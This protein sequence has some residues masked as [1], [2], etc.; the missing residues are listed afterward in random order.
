MS[1]QTT[2]SYDA[3]VIGAGVIGACLALGLAK[4][5][6][7]KV[8]L[9]EKN[10]T[11][12]SSTFTPEPNIR[13]TALG[14]SSQSLLSDLGV[15]QS[16]NEQQV[17]AY[18]KMY[19]WD[20]NS[21]GELT[22]AASDYAVEALGFIVDHF[23][24]QARLQNMVSEQANVD[25]YY[26]SDIQSLDFGSDLL[27]ASSVNASAMTSIRIKQNGK[28]VNLRT[29]WVFAA[30]GVNSEVRQLADIGI[31]EHNY[32]Q[33][34]IVA[35]IRSQH[36][37][38]NTAWQRFL[39]TG[40][41]A[42]L[43]LKS[44]ECSIVWSMPTKQANTLCELSEADFSKRLESALQ[45]RFGSIELTSQRYMFP[46]KSVKADAYLKKFVVLV[47]DAA[48]GIHPMAGQGANLGFE[49]IQRLL[50]EVDGMSADHP[51]LR[52][53][54]R[55]YERQQKLSNY[56]MDTF[57]TSLD[58]IFRTD[59]VLLSSLRRIGLNTINKHS[60]IKELF[61]QHVLGKAH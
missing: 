39:S 52:R 4:K 24:L 3:V 23:A 25:A 2:S 44:G 49:D 34:G 19:V 27:D 30:D 18:D 26:L 50:F 61:A 5:N 40:P 42:L 41:I 51:K 31:S 37:H 60:S 38:Q 9:V 56:T 6:G 13:A 47:G 53:A 32:Q 28:D 22:F 55:R 54:F 58:S 29:Q 57:M 8:A 10:A 48:H 17:C 46:L 33:Q 45:S 15:W 12:Q 14:L 7:W 1:K 36:D 43:P 11:L 20:E 35:K 16:L 21:D 59:N